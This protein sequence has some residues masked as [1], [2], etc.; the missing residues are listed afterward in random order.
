MPQMRNGRHGRLCSRI[1]VALGSEGGD[2]IGGADLHAVAGGFPVESAL[3]ATPVRE[4]VSP[5]AH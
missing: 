5:V 3:Q 2:L 1:L 4:M